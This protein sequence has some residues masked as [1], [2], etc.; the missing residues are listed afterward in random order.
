LRTREAQIKF[1]K[2]L[3]AMEEE[4]EQEYAEKCRKDVEDYKKEKQLE[5]EKRTEKMNKNKEDLLAQ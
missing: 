5:E 3:K 2:K 1:D 4:K